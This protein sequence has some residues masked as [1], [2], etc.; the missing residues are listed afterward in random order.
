MKILNQKIKEYDNLVDVIDTGDGLE[1]RKSDIVMNQ[2][3][4]DMGDYILDETPEDYSWD[5][6]AVSIHD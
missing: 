2:Y 6:Y 1:N 3:Y 5:D 4:K